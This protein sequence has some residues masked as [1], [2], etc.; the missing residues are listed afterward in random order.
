MLKCTPSAYFSLQ[1]EDCYILAGKTDD[2]YATQIV[3]S[4]M[5]SFC[6]LIL[7]MSCIRKLSSRKLTRRNNF[8]SLAMGFTKVNIRLQFLLQES[9]SPLKNLWKTAK[10]PQTKSTNPKHKGSR[11]SLQSSHINF[12]TNNFLSHPICKLNFKG[13]SQVIQKHSKRKAVMQ[14]LTWNTPGFRMKQS[15]YSCWKTQP[16]LNW[17]VN[18]NSCTQK[19]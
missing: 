3:W 1:F 17:S 13:D 16:H 8:Q 11:L 4:H 12:I 5:M 10:P 15:D 7:I 19:H 9:V 18:M 2:K 6:S 14:R